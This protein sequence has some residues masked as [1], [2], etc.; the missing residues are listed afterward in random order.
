MTTN[1]PKYIIREVCNEAGKWIDFAA[2]VNLMDN[3]LRE[4]VYSQG[5]DDGEFFKV[6]CKLHREKYGEEFEPNKANPVW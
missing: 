6:Y 1:N 5:L 3:D 2:A 4:Q